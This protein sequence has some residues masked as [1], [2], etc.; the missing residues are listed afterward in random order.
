MAIP[1]EARAM[2]LVGWSTQRVGGELRHRMARNFAR[3]HDHEYQGGSF[4]RSASEGGAY[5]W[6][7]DHEGRTI[8]GLTLLARAL[9]Q[10]P[11]TLAG[12][13][14]LLPSHLNE[15]GYLG[16]ILPA[17]QADE[18]QLSGHSWLLRGLCE[19]YLWTGEQ[20]SLDQADRVARE[21]FLPTRDA[22]ASYAVAGRAAGAGA[23]AGHLLDGAEGLWHSS[24]DVGC[25]FIPLDGLT[26]VYELAPSEALRSL[27]E[28][29]L[30]RYVATDFVGCALQTHAT[31]SGLRGLLR[32]YELTGDVAWLAHA[33]RIFALYLREGLTE[34]YANH[35]WFTRPEWT[36]PCAV[37]DSFLVALAL[38]RHTGEAA[39]LDDAH[40]IYYN[41][42]GYGQ[43]PNG[44]WGCDNCVG[45]SDVFLHPSEG[46]FEA[47]WCCTM[48]GAE[49]LARAAEHA[50]LLGPDALTVP[51][52]G[53]GVTRL[54]L[55]EGE[56]TLRQTVGY[57]REGW[58]RLEA[59]TG[60]LSAPPRVR[61]FVPPGATAGS[62]SLAHATGDAPFHRDGR[63]LETDL[64]ARAG[65]SLELRFA[66][67][68][69]EYPTLTER[70]LLGHHTY[71]HGPL[72]LGVRGAESAISVSPEAEPEHLG[73]ARYALPGLAE[74]L[75]PINDL[76]YLPEEEARRDRRQILFHA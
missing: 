52:Y 39:Y 76:M 11:T 54:A 25:A 27:I 65:E 29:V 73:G 71:R 75:E 38:W 13:L 40:R 4:F 26:Q 59:L 32:Y 12:H 37:V 30:E 6:P 19:H 58:V 18:Q 22:Y 51:L 23:H 42:M 49:G 8:L 55:P 62:V 24:T 64:P 21:L 5:G 35:N 66:L 28:L 34:N 68:L 43:R 69:R 10:E 57:P 2:S 63:F 9:H 48:R 14:D 72:I 3:L 41:A 20:R 16:H 1:E 7:G 31:L 15:R 17:G 74:A 67:P 56:V 60:R 36:E 33:K 44:G 53:D 46:A 45:A 70:A 47:W 61:V 50:Y